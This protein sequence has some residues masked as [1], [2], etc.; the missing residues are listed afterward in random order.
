MIVVGV[1]GW[2]WFHLNPHPL[3]AEGAPPKSATPVQIVGSD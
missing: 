1:T 2:D 3:K